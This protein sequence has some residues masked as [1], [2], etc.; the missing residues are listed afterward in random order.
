MCFNTF[1]KNI[2]KQTYNIW[3]SMAL[4]STSLILPAQSQKGIE[5]SYILWG[6]TGYCSIS[7]HSDLTKTVGRIGASFGA[8]L[9]YNIRDFLIQSGVGLSYY[10]SQMTI[11]DTLYITP[12]IDSDGDAYDGNY[13]FKN[14]REIQQT[15]SI[16]VPILFGYSFNNFYFLAG[17][18][19][20]FNLSG[21]SHSTTE[22]KSSGYYSYLVGNNNDG[23][24]T[25]LPK[26]GFTTA[27]RSTS[28]TFD[29]KTI[30]V[31]SLELGYT[32]GKASPYRYQKKH[33]PNYR[34]ALFFDYGITPF[35]SSTPNLINT[36]TTL[37]GYEYEATINSLITYQNH[38]EYLY[39]IHT[40][41]KLT[42]LFHRASKHSCNCYKR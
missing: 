18:K 36:P 9:E 23:M 4:L 2:I 21:E 17:E 10:S 30:F 38:S 7:N 25:D 41:I 39:T 13:S 27:T 5:H 32:F 35:D 15:L 37:K 1:F 34:I 24:I 6:S 16:E 31:T 20:L 14:N 8:G 11:A 3:L 26:E 22:V 28:S 19:F 33:K 42:V 12:M 40:G 29:V